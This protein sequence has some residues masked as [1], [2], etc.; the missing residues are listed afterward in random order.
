[1]KKKE[2]IV[3]LSG[4]LDS[5]VLTHYVMRRRDRMPIALSFNYGQ[6]HKKELNLARQT[7]KKLGIKHKIIKIPLDKLFDNSALLDKKTKM[8]GEHY[9]H[10][11]QRVTV[12]PNRNMI[13]LSFA[14]GLAENLKICEV[15]YAAHKNDHAIYPDCRPAFLNP[16]N[17]ASMHATYSCVQVLAPFINKTK[18]DLVGIGYKLDID[19]LTTWSCYEGKKFAC[20]TCA[21]CQERLEAFHKNKLMDPLEYEIQ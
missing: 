13:M 18:K 6:R 11:N 8:P 1:M 3:L 21:T 10:K 14:I 2:C 20:G 17:K 7:A 9:T 5:T 16:M 12:V 15:Y 4:G 19:F